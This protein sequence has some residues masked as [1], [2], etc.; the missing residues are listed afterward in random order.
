MKVIIAIA[1]LLLSTPCLLGSTNP[2]AQQLLSTALQQSSIFGDPSTPLELQIDFVAQLNVPTGGHL[3][4]RWAQKDRWWSKVSLG[5]FEQIKIQNGEWSYTARNLGFTPM[6][7]Q[8]LLNLIHLTDSSVYE[9]QKAKQRTENGIPITC[10][11]AAREDYKQDKRE[12]CLDPASNEIL[13][14]AWNWQPDEKR[15]ELYSDYFEFQGHHY[16][17]KLEY[18][19]NSSRVI[20]AEV[21][22][23]VPAPFDESLL[24]PPKGA[25]GRRHCPGMKPAVPIKKVELPTIGFDSHNTIALT[26]LTDGTVGDIQLIARGGSRLDEATMAALKQWKFKPAMCG[27]DPVVSDIEIETSVRHY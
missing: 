15:R 20:K 25:I 14:Q 2:D 4:V 9:G 23:L 5:G 22:S 27:T 7:V 26:I 8:E 3:T 18:E 13:S 21:T 10:V 19:E 1:A 11:H 16:P 24:S 12:I 17:R 6:R